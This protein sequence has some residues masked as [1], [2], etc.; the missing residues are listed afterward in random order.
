[1]NTV[2]QLAA[3]AG[4]SINL[5]YS[6]VQSGQLPHV[7]LGAPG[8]RGKIMISPAD[9]EA[10]LAARRVGG[11]VPRADNQPRPAHEFK[12]VKVGPAAG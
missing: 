3:L 9:W 2:K 5:I 10:F 11:A 8:R 7:R 1:M 4:V 6:W 12:H